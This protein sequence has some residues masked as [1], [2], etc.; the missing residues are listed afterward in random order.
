MANFRRKH[1]S[2]SL[3]T[4]VAYDAFSQVLEVVFCKGGIY[5]Y[6]NISP[7]QYEQL[8][9]SDSLGEYFNTNIRNNKQLLYQKVRS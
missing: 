5:E 1:A 3:I 9:R 2:S 8:R 4:S 7:D 6:S